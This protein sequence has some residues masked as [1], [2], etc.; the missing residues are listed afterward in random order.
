MTEHSFQDK[1]ALKSLEQFRLLSKNG[2][3]KET[4]WTILSCILVEINEHLEVV[5]LGTGSKCI[6]QNNLSPNGDILNDSHAEIICRRSFLLYLYEQINLSYDNNS[7]IFVFEKDNKNLTLN[8]NVRFH[9]FTTHV[10]CGDAAIFPKQN[11]DN[12]GE[13]IEDFASTEEADDNAEQPAKKRKLDIYRTGAKCLEGD[14]Q[15]PKLEGCGYHI[16]GAVRRKPGRG[17]PTLSVSCSDK[18]SKWC[19]LVLP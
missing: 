19:H 10:P 5:A 4:E 8:N 16:L 11:N 3:P 13:I 14:Q 18:I 9:F 15:D 6:G 1:I 12:F 2:K 17:D 7:S